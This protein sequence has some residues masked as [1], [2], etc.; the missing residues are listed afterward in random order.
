MSGADGE[1]GF[2]GR[3]P[4]DVT[5]TV[6][7]RGELRIHYI[8][9]TDKPT[10]VNFTNTTHISIWPARRNGEIYDHVVVLNADKYTPIDATSIPLGP[11]R[12]WP[13]R[14][15]T[16][17]AHTRLASGSRRRP[18]DPMRWATTTLG[19][20]PVGRIATQ[21]LAARVLEPRA[22]RL[23]NAHHRPVEHPVVVVA[24]RIEDLLVGLLDPLANVC[25]PRKSNGVPATAGS[26]R[27][28]SRWRQSACTYRH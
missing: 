19:A 8:A 21:S 7:R 1:M 2:P 13:E 16:S 20:Q 17:A 23:L 25:G 6:N 12:R 18:A 4:I 27:A 14:R 5:Y 10:I 26:A 28:G 11:L 3:L 22:G 9:T 15:S 24:Q